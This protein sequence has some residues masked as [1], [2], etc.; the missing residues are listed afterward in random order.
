V[1]VKVNNNDFWYIQW[2]Q[3]EIMDNWYNK[4]LNN[5]YHFAYMNNIT[6]MNDIKKAD[7]YW[8]LNRISMAKMLSQYAT[9]LLWRVP[10]TSKQINFWDVSSDLDAK[11]NNWV[12]LAY[13]LWIM[14][15]NMKNNEFRPY[16]LVTRAEF[17]TAL[18]RLLYWLKDWAPNYYSTH[19]EKLFNEWIISNKNPDLYELRWYVMLMLMRSSLR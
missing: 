8:S 3:K 2:N 1:S 11:Y 18:S 14:W 4:E 17:G 9:K 12:T 7:M 16:D 19:L 13:Q 15:I 10:D 6:T 5:A